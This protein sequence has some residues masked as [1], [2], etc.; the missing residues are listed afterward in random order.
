MTRA[1]SWFEE[2]ATVEVAREDIVRRL[3]E[4][5]SLGDAG[6]EAALFAPDA[7]RYNPIAPEGVRGREAIRRVSE[8]LAKA[9]PVL[10]VS[11]LHISAKGDTVAAEWVATGRQSGPLELPTGSL[12]PTNREVTMR[13]A[14][15]YRFNREGL[16]SEDRGYYDLAGFL[17][18]LGLKPKG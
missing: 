5:M 3:A 1:D 18:Q 7:V 16:I 9:F 13:G 6:A 14:N 15:F 12:P 2:M 17:Q 11:M 10:N 8:N 4:V